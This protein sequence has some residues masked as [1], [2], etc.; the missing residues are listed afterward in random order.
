MRLDYVE[1]P[2]LGRSMYVLYPTGDRLC[3]YENTLITLLREDESDALPNALLIDADFCT[4]ADKQRFVILLPNP[5]NGKWNWDLNADLPNDLAD[6]PE[7][8][9]LFNYQPNLNDLGIYHN[10][11]NARYFMGVGTG[12][13]M[14]QTLA[15]CN[16]VNVGGIFTI[17][18]SLSAKAKAISTGAAVS[19]ILWNADQD[20]K[21]FF[22]A[23]NGVDTQGDGVRHN[24]VNDAQFV[25]IED[26]KPNELTAQTIRYGWGKLFSKVCRSNSW[27]YGDVGPRIVRDDY[28]FIVHEDDTQL[29]DNKG[30]GHTWFE[31][32][33]SCAKADPKMKVPLMIFNHGGADTPGNICNSIKM[34]EVA[35][36]EGFLVVCPW[37]TA[38]WGWNID[39]ADDQY[40]DIGYLRALIAHMEQTY[41]VDETR[42]YIGGFS[43]GSAMSQV[44]AMTNPE[45]IAAVVADNT[46]FSQNRNT[47]PFAIAGK[48]KLD[49]DFRLP[50]WYTYGTRDVEYP[51]VRGSGQQ[52]QY[53]FW[54][55]YNN[56][57]CKQTPYIATPEMSGVGVSG[58]VIEEYYPNPRYP[59]RKYTTHRFF[60]NDAVPQ[61]L[62]NYSLADG[63][64]HDCNPEEAWLGWNYVKQFS[65]MPDGSLVIFKRD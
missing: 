38:R 8:L 58:D 20:S 17:G 30:I 34:H 2:E 6:V 24:S 21:D 16:P 65:R 49:Y 56:I 62:Y 41:A 61:N 5:V 43:N 53:D 50:V 42:V 10:M 26:G 40:D 12:A 19:A 31:Y 55:S 45:I 28:Q 35:E 59:K 37:S 3:C 14:A 36:R 39:L 48:K 25:R 27:K 1:Y 13:S 60:S 23:L 18:G 57:T 32:V 11:H 63:K 54:K 44:F 15:A 29:G 9:R 46:M 33:P 4:L 51:A 22:S 47:K 7:I 64:G 52:V